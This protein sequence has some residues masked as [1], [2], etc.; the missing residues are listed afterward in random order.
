MK[1]MFLILV[2][3]CFGSVAYAEEAANWV[4]VQDVFKAQGKTHDSA[5]VINLAR[6]D[7]QVMKD[8]VTL[9]PGLGVEHML[10]FQG[11]EEQALVAADLAL[12]ESE[13]DQVMA[14]LFA[15]GFEVTALHNHLI[16]TKPPVIFLHVEAQGNAVTLARALQSSLPGGCVA[17]PPPTPELA[18]KRPEWVAVQ[19]ILG[20]A[21]KA[22]DD[23]MEIGIPR[24]E[25]VTN[26]GV[27]LDPLM[28]ITTMLLFQV[29]PEGEHAGMIASTAEFVL[30]PE[31]VNPVAKVLR[32]N[33]LQVS[34][35]HNHFL[36]EKPRLIFVHCWGLGTPEKV[37]SAYKAALAKIGSIKTEKKA[38]SGHLK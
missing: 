9:K 38:K 12:Q 29:L 11:T 28:G 22:Q 23:V 6:P 21:G 19:E 7:L 24:T 16:G 36:F 31:E 26:R 34:A 4:N 17:E 33:G 30:L 18:Q 20:L 8:N 2:A 15:A 3:L 5:L 27:T 13:V 32:E 14:N 1:N 35:I 37:A 10:M 25:R